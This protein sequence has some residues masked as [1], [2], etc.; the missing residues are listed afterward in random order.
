MKLSSVSYSAQQWGF[1]NNTNQTLSV[2]A[3]LTEDLVWISDYG[4]EWTEISSAQS[5]LY[6]SG[7]EHATPSILTVTPTDASALSIRPGQ[8]L[9]LKWTIH[10]L[11]SGTPGMLA[12]DDL[13]VTFSRARSLV[14]HIF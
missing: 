11:R 6:G 4:S 13:T 3:A 1:K 5:N 9:M 10:S 8:V 14:L 2:S 12:I 7:T